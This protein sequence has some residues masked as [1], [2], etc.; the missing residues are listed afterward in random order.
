MRHITPKEAFTEQKPEIGHLRIFGCPDYI[1]VPREK[2]TKLDPARKQGIFVGYNESAK[3]YRIYIPDQKKME[4]SRD[5][6]FEEDAAYRRS[7]HT[8]SDSDQ[9]DAS[10]ELLDSPSPL[11]KKETLEDDSIEPIDPVDPIVPDLVPRDTLVLGQR[12][13][14][15]WLRQTLQ[16]AEGHSALFI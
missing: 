4:L 11:A 2:R 9:Q 14:L 16:H 1:H 10:Q 7:R 3:A 6:T 13:R 5:I 8:N 12:R 15:P